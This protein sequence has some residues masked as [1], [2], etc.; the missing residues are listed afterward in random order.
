MGQSD[1]GREV[2][3]HSQPRK[4]RHCQWLMGPLNVLILENWTQAA[5]KQQPR[6]WRPAAAISQHYVVTTRPARA[7]V[8]AHHIDSTL[9]HPGGARRMNLPQTQQ[10]AQSPYNSM[11]IKPHDTVRQ[12]RVQL[13]NWS[14]KNLAIHTRRLSASR[15]QWLCRV[16]T[17]K[18]GHSGSTKTIIMAGCQP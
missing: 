1:G 18:C 8:N 5:I 11:D 4:Q 6:R 14:S 15:T 2:V 16:R 9:V 10:P 17:W 7:T 12:L 13:V 3:A